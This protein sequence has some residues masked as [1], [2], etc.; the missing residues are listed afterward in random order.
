MF[1]ISVMGF[2]L[3]LRITLAQKCIHIIYTLILSMKV[4]F[5]Y[6]YQSL[7]GSSINLTEKCTM[8][9]LLHCNIVPR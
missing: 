7:T 1:T 9:M 5:R 8:M 3:K 6:Q 2:P 4:L